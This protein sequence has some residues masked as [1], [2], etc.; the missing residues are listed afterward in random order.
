MSNTYKLTAAGTQLK[1]YLV[2]G[3]FRKTKVHVSFRD[4]AVC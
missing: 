3:K 4:G 1:D 2:T